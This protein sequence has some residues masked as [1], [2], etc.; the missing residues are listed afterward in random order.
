LGRVMLPVLVPSM[1]ISGLLVALLAFA[2]VTSV[3]LLAPPGR[4]TF[5]LRIFTVMANAP[6]ALV[7]ALCCV[8]VVVAVA[9]VAVLLRWGLKDEG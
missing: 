7:A 4:S 6:Q 9:G 1:L 8:Y 3:L 2:D 5:A